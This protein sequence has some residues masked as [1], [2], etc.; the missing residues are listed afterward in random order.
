[1]LSLIFPRI[2]KL[3][4]WFCWKSRRNSRKLW[5]SKHFLLPTWYRNYSWK[6]YQWKVSV[7]SLLQL[8]V[9]CFLKWKIV[10]FMHSDL[11]IYAPCVGYSPKYYIPSGI[12]MIGKGNKHRLKYSIFIL[13]GYL[14][15]LWIYNSDNESHWYSQFVF[16]N[17]NS[18]SKTCLLTLDHFSRSHLFYCC[19]LEG[20]S[21]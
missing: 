18:V 4:I 21:G 17:L 13:I 8:L 5:R 15:L 3:R 12:R 20:K 6:G 7:S 2:P 11:S 19:F 10:W 1:M 16:D 14:I 9:I